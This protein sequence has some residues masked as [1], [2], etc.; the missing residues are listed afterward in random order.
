MEPT[1]SQ[2]DVQASNPQV[3][4]PGLTEKVANM[5]PTWIQQSIKKRSFFLRPLA[6]DILVF[7]W[8]FASKWNQVGFKLRANIDINLKAKNQLTVSQPAF[9]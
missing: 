2:N 4:S 8:N 9:N 5:A 7:W 1:W 3:L 6:S